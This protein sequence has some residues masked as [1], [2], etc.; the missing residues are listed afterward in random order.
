MLCSIAG[1]LAMYVLSG[2]TQYSQVNSYPLGRLSYR[3]ARAAIPLRTT[4]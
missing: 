4:S 2:P 3:Q 1:S